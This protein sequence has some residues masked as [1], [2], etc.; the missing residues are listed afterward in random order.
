MAP[1]SERMI[2]DCPA[3]EKLK[4]LK[5]RSKVL[6]T[7]MVANPKVWPAQQTK[8]VRN[9]S[10]RGL[11]RSGRSCCGGAQRWGGR[12]LVLA[13]WHRVAGGGVTQRESA[14]SDELRCDVARARMVNALF[15]DFIVLLDVTSIVGSSSDERNNR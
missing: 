12:R 15:A 13:G 5:R 11:R 3:L 14:R 10:G 7:L 1:S 8:L 4:V 2:G 6:A 9:G